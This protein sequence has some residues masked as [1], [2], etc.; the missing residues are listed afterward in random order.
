M[1]NDIT[2]AVA[3][4][5]DDRGNIHLKTFAFLPL[6]G[7]QDKER[8][9][10]APYTQWVNSGDLI[11]VPGSVLDYQWIVEYLMQETAGW[12]LAGVAF[13]RWRID[14]FRAEAEKYGWYPGVWEPVGQGYKDLSPRV[15]T[16]ETL[17]LEERLR[18]GNAPLLNMAAANAV[19][20]SDPAGN[21]KL[22][23]NKSTQRIDP[24]VA[25]IMSVYEVLHNQEDVLD[26]AAMIG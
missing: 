2:A 14:V 17:L 15:E 12:N 19:S 20:L 3:A 13:D 26:I 16:F 11:A 5:S 10:K 21:R 1:R 6:N 22:D 8:L 4:T 18:H 23:K 24:L 7:L 9:D 25:A